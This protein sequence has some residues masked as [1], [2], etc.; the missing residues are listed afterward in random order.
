MKKIVLNH[1][2]TLKHDTKRTFVIGPKPKYEYN[3]LK[4]DFDWI[5]KIHPLY[6]IILSFFST[7]KGMDEGCQ[8]IADFFDISLE[9]VVH[10]IQKL[11]DSDFPTIAEYDGAKSVFPRNILVSVDNIMTDTNIMYN[12]EEFLYNE[13]D[14]DTQRP[15]I[16]PLGLVLMVNNKCLTDCQYCYADKSH[17]CGELPLNLIENILKQAV[18]NRIRE[19]EVV[20]GE[21]FMYSNWRLLLEILFKYGYKPEL[22]S[23]KVPLTEDDVAYIKKYKIPLQISLDSTDAECLSKLLRVN[24]NY[25]KLILRSF[26]Y[27]E[28]HKVEYQVATVLTK[29][30]CSQSSIKKIHE[31]L[32]DKDFLQRWELRP[33]FRSLY[34][35]ENFSD[36]KL[37]KQEIDIVEHF[38]ISTL[39]SV[40][41]RCKILW[42]RDNGRQYFT[43][44]NGSKS[45]SGAR[46]SA[47][48]SHMVI[49][50]DGKV[51]ICEQLYWNPNFII[52]DVK[53][54]TISD[55]WNSNKALNLLEL[56]QADL[57]P[58]SACRSC[59]LWSECAKYPNKCYADVI[60]AYGNENWD[61]PDPRCAFANPLIN[62]L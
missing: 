4:I 43:G 14:L 16:T 45:F 24:N 41:N 39:N 30:N 15:F 33:V 26:E 34:S 13:I 38:V 58:Q 28:K 2:Y 35:S 21:I 61:F 19:V 62:E 49:L 25:G 47:N 22:I 9:D 7:P 1:C 53:Y 29:K 54:Q 17:L 36:L 56:K 8:Q 52:G 11:V 18:T 40:D 42:S 48:F 12:Y 23:T 57:S 51:T 6:A 46:C 32:N 27:L 55:I 50:P 44:K 20:G 5:S 37:S 59:T 3:K 60:K 10:L 31:F